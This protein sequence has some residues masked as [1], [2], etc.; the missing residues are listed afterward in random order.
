MCLREAAVGTPMVFYDVT[1]AEEE[2]YFG[3][4]PKVWQEE[5]YNSLIE[6]LTVGLCSSP[7]EWENMR[8]T[9]SKWMGPD[10]KCTKSQARTLDSLA[11]VVANASP[12]AKSA[13]LHPVFT[14][15][16]IFGDKES[17]SGSSM[18]TTSNKQEA[19]LLKTKQLLTAIVKAGT[20]G[21]RA[22]TKQYVKT[23]LKQTTTRNKA[24]PGMGKNAARNARRRANVLKG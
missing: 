12:V 6:L 19:H 4:N 20:P 7:A 10:K 21:Q 22:N 5:A 24:E 16:D 13:L 1:K 8:W 23:N 18:A 14:A 15:R 3:T 2:G 11:K 9:P 17:N